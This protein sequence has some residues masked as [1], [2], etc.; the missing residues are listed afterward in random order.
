MSLGD[1]WIGSLHVVSNRFVVWA[2]R[3]LWFPLPYLA[4][5]ALSEGI[6]GTSRG[7]TGVAAVALWSMWTLGLLALFVPHTIT[8]T[9]LRIVTP[10]AVTASIWAGFGGASPMVTALALA[11]TGIVTVLAHSAP[12][13]TDFVNGTSYGDE[14][15]LLL[16]PP[17]ALL[18]GP[19]PLAW[20]VTVAGVL[21]G[22]LL[23]GAS[24]TIAGIICV[25]V[26]LPL[27]AVAI[28]SLHSLTQRW[29]VFVP[30]GLVVHDVT[31]LIDPQLFRRTDI[32]RIGPALANS[33]ALDVSQGALG[34]SL[35][36][37]FEQPMTIVQRAGQDAQGRTSEP[38][39]ILVSPTQPGEVLAE[40]DRRKIV[41]A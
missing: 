19:I 6:D 14:R 12:F 1:D 17:A 10:A 24:H 21:A 32:R 31:S 37:R 26:G 35:E 16:R 34:L 40:A 4:G 23:L 18:L 29:L 2:A 13:G 3:L 28:R 15:R 36:V 33:D 30:S 38:E 39:A 9:Y 25:V 20:I 27:S 7:F 8:L 41:V 11:F 5:A 22:P